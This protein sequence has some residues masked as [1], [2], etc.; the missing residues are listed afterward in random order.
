[1]DQE[2][3]KIRSKRAARQGRG[4]I[5]DDSSWRA[6]SIVPWGRG[7]NRM[8]NGGCGVQPRSY[9]FFVIWRVDGSQN[10][11]GAANNAV[12]WSSEEAAKWSSKHRRSAH[13]DKL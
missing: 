11:H 1:M 8:R 3:K 6:D 5:S 2:V 12:K 4:A 10:L 9:D 7:M 13:I